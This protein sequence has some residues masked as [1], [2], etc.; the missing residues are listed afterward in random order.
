MQIQNITVL[1]LQKESA[2]IRHVR[3]LEFK[4]Y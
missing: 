1:I 3:S 4:M 2:S